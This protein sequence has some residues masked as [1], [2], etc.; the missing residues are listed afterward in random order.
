M[1]KTNR[2]TEKR[3]ERKKVFLKSGTEKIRRA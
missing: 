3:S 2:L 1:K